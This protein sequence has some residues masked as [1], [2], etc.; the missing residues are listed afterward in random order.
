MADKNNPLDKTTTSPDESSD[1]ENQHRYQTRATTPGRAAAEG[2]PKPNPVE[3]VEVQTE[4]R[5]GDQVKHFDFDGNLIPGPGKVFGA[6]PR[7][8]HTS[9]GGHRSLNPVSSRQ[10]SNLLAK[11]ALDPDRGNPLK[12]K[13]PQPQQPQVKTLPE[14]TRFIPDI[15]E[16]NL[17]PVNIPTETDEDL[18]VARKRMEIEYTRVSD[19]LKGEL[20]ALT[21][22]YEDDEEYFEETAAAINEMIANIRIYITRLGQTA[23][24][25]EERFKI[26]K[27]TTHFQ[28]LQK[29]FVKERQR[30]QRYL[31]QKPRTQPIVHQ[32]SNDYPDQKR[33]AKAPPRPERLSSEA[34]PH[35]YNDW[36]HRFLAYS[37]FSDVTSQRLSDQKEHL[38]TCL[39]ATLADLV[40]SHQVAMPAYREDMEEG[41]EEQAD[42]P[43]WLQFLDQYFLRR[44]PMC[45]RR[46]EVSTQRPLPG[47]CD[48]D[49]IRRVT[50]DC[51]VAQI[52]RRFMY[53]EDMI[54]AQFMA[55]VNNP[56][57]RAIL[58]NCEGAELSQIT[59]IADSVDSKFQGQYTY[60]PQT[61]PI[62]GQGQNAPRRANQTPRSQ[63]QQPRQATSNPTPQQQPAPQRP[64]TSR[65]RNGQKCTYCSKPG[66]SEDKCYIKKRNVKALA[67]AQSEKE[68][69][70]AT[71]E[72]PHTANTTVTASVRAT[73]PCG[74]IP[75]TDF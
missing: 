71:K 17:D 55:H 26:D 70:E 40:T 19:K 48:S 12:P 72:E 7:T 67:V 66:H 25:I 58:S 45:N 65:P 2:D 57:L 11:M 61:F 16:D 46:S 37:R 13:N 63:Q 68:E 53:V 29:I 69:A 5:I 34:T 35:E 64:P 73:G 49:Y 75:H 9:R 21:G 4:A 62:P 33:Y 18:K 14:A 20:L 36:T 43:T 27:F 42:Y 23:N 41:V 59:E 10:V 38:K 30:A 51:G 22:Y 60:L 8:T 32:I 6:I 50:R 52:H 54:I 56:A 39:G 15:A 44:H 1:G 3:E 31:G 74:S 28:D 47:E 24:M